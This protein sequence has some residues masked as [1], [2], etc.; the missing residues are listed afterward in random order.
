MQV[1][2]SSL[3][4]GIFD[5]GIGGLT[6]VRAVKELL[7]N[8]SIIYFGDTG[9]VPYGNKSKSTITE[10][11]LQITRFLEEKGVKMIVIACN[12]A[13]AHALE[14]VVR[15]TKLPVVGV[16]EPGARAAIKKTKS[17]RIGVIGT[18]GTINSKA[19]N[20]AIGVLDPTAEV[21]GQACPLFVPL[22][23][24]GWFDH[25]AT[26]LIIREYLKPLEIKHIDTLVM[27]CTHYPLLRSAIE[28]EL[29]DSIAIVDSAE[30]IASEVKKVLKE[31]SILT[32]SKEKPAY[33]YFVS[34]LN[35][36]FK[37]LGQ[38]FL[39]EPFKSVEMHE[40]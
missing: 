3:P 27:G 17:K 37:E 28:R 22:A 7:P 15:H 25:P 14:D 29:F 31:H 10:Y 33:S 40:W 20:H 5:S 26:R 18:Q 1:S 36:R 38:S 13:T 21:F 24:E 30:E 35:Y 32:T 16:V 34:D 23:E 12:T 19:Y 4:I 2:Q 39:G 9:R 8:E 6:V 11:S